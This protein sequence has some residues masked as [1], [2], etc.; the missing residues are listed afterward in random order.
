MLIAL[1][2]AWSFE[3][4]ADGYWDRRWIFMPPLVVLVAAVQA[5]R[6]WRFERLRPGS[7]R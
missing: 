3:D 6:K 7:S 5:F 2:G 4:I 1:I